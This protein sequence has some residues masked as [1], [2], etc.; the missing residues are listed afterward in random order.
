MGKGVV[1]LG[2]GN[3]AVK[4][5][6][7]L[8]VKE[9]N[10][11]FKN[12]E[13]TVERGTRATYVGRDGLIKESDLQNTNLVLN[14]NFEELGSDLVTNGNFA[15]DSDWTKQNSST[16]S[17]GVGN[18]IANGD[19]G[20][21]GTN[22]SL[23]QGVGMIVGKSYNISFSA[24]QTGGTGNFQV[25]QAYLLGFNQSITSSFAN[26]S[27]FITPLDFGV[28][29]GKISIGGFVVGDTFEV[30]NVSIKQVDPNNRWSSEASWS[31][32]DGK[33]KYSAAVQGHYLKQ[34]I[35]PSVA[36]GKTVKIQF[37]ISDVQA[38]KTA[39]LK[40]EIS[41]SSEV[42]FSYTNFS[43]GT[44]TYYHT[45]TGGLDRLN[46]V[47]AISGTGGAFSIDNIIVQE[48]KT[49]TPRIDFLNN[50]DGHL[51]LEPARTNLV[52]KSEDF[53][54]SYW[55]KSGATVESGFTS[56][57]G[58][59]NAFKLVEDTSNGVHRVGRA[60]FTANVERT[61]SVFAKK[62]ERDYIS[63]FENNAGTSTTVK[64]VIFNLNNGTYY[65]NNATF[66]SN[67]KVEL[68]SNGWYRCSV[69]MTNG[70]LQVPS[71]GV[72]AD[73]LT[74]SYQGDGTSGVYIWGSQFEEASYPTSYIPTVG[75]AATRSADV[76]KDSGTVA[77]FNSTEGVLFADVATL[78]E[79]ST[80]A[81]SAI[82]LGFN[83]TNK[84][85]IFSDSGITKV[86]LRRSDSTNNQIL[87]V[88]TASESKSFNK[89]A[90]LYKS[91]QNKVFV[92][93]SRVA[94]TNFDSFTFDYVG[95][96]K[97]FTKLEFA[98]GSS[99][100]GIFEGKCKQLEVYKTGFSDDQ[101]I[102]LTGT[103]GTHFFESYTSMAGALTY[104]IQ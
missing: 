103:L 56:P 38:G 74:N 18:V 45:I 100:G 40:L 83:I 7:L 50:T 35:S 58:T 91:G 11:R 93:G 10:R 61:L 81:T 47:P 88:L 23:Y 27:F 82:T 79:N 53:S 102:R 52:V 43:A 63:L 12:T 4:D 29:T 97:S 46:F 41:G 80:T 14:G 44:H 68:I 34:T 30:D 71:F 62:G 90:I 2:D 57:D 24:R 42:V 48:I 51:L 21:T 89:I 20:N 1:K 101:L 9:T 65:N 77:D 96:S 70:G 59:D 49:A 31:I 6:N 95:N 78:S 15:T 75:T 32:E 26:Y 22:W 5:G 76:C 64:G 104:T 84:V 16:I 28:N 8:A 67:V 39:F 25:A 36:A 92:N 3:W 94:N 73:G 98:N 69:T 33:A 60:T 54:D 55:T 85:M 13:F 99:T 66:Y 86:N 72:S 17:G 37:D 87:N 19:L